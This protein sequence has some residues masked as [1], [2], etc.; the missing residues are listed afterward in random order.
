M[1]LDMY[2]NGRKFFWSDWEKP[3]GKRRPMEDG[4]EVSEHVLELGYWRKHP[5]LHGFIV[6]EFARGIDECQDIDLDLDALRRI[7]LASETDQ[8]P[9]TQ[10]FFFGESRPEDKA[11]TK[12]Q[13]L[14]AIQWLETQEKGVFRTVVYR[15][16]W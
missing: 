12:H 13:I 4:F 2:L 3:E 7:L 16:S 1:G 6:R 10:G 14:A 11:N 5:N 9:H 15:A 8:L